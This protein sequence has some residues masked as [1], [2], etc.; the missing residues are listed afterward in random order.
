M[1]VHL[2]SQNLLSINTHKG[3]YIC[4]QLM[5]GLHGALA[6]WQYYVYELFQGMEVVKVFMD[7][8][9]ITGI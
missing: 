1:K 8:A 9:Q 3:L 4:N 6:I 5:Y 7:S 2:D